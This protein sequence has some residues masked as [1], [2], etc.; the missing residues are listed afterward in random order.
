MKKSLLLGAALAL[1]GVNAF[2]I[3]ENVIVWEEIYKQMDSN[4]QRYQIMLKIMEFKD[5]EFTPM[6][7]SALDGLIASRLDL[8]SSGERH[9]K[10][11]LAKLLVTELGNLKSVE[12]AESVFAAYKDTADAVLKAAAAESLGNM[13]AAQYAENLAFDLAAINVGPVASQGRDQE[14]VALGLVRGL[15][16]MR[17]PVG[18]EPVFLASFGWYS[19]KSAVK[20]TAKDASAAMVDDPTESLLKVFLANPSLDI[21]LA[22]LETEL[23]SKAPT[24]KKRDMARQ[25]LAWGVDRAEDDAIR[26]RAVQKIRLTAMNGLVSLEDKSAD[27]VPL[28][29]RV[30]EMDKKND[31]TLEETARSLVAMGVNGTDAA[32][33]YMA[34]LLTT[35]NSRQR[36]QANTARDKM[37]IKQLLSSMQTAKNPLVKNA[38]LQAQYINYDNG[39][40]R[41]MEDVLKALP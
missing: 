40:L 25:A 28:L 41:Q 11:E 12:A 1:F 14:I 15:G 16:A 22:A 3:N 31:A 35:Y 30:F 24:D 33:S 7:Q 21:K 34:S 20:E 4:A 26:I 6:L 2:A 9:D 29:V 8:G 13:R 18:F 39:L 38:L 19:G 23:N 27:T 5:R 37:L 32:A 36:S 17:S 10:I